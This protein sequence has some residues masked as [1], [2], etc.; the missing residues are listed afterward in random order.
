MD[1][2]DFDRI[3]C[4]DTGLREAWVETKSDGLHMCS[5][6]VLRHK[7]EKDDLPAS[8]DRYVKSK[9]RLER[10]CEQRGLQVPEFDC[11]AIFRLVNGLPV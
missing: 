4:A 9:S 7:G 5:Q 10:L 8:R 11:W 3:C 6:F 1:I 2:K